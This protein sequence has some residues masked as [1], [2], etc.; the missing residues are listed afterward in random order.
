MEFRLRQA[1]DPVLIELLDCVLERYRVISCNDAAKTLE[2]VM[3][4]R[5]PQKHQACHGVPRDPES[6]VS[7][8]PT[9]SMERSDAGYVIGL[10]QHHAARASANR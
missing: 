9:Y 3:F 4:E 8:A 10:G 2:T 1:C 6:V 5:V 7:I